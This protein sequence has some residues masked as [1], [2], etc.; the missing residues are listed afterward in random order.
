ML[1]DQQFAYNILL[2]TNGM[3]WMLSEK[4]LA[5]LSNN[6]NQA[7]FFAILGRLNSQK[8]NQAAIIYASELE[9]QVRK[10]I[11]NKTGQT[12]IGQLLTA[13][14]LQQGAMAGQ[15]GYPSPFKTI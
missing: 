14:A 11:T 15:M 4:G 13:Q 6:N 2:T 7:V 1:E 8:N 3:K 5:W 9:Q 10:Y 12:A